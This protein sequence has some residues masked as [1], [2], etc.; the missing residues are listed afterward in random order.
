MGIPII[1]APCEAESQCA[2]L[3]KYNL[4]HATAT[5]DADALVFGTKILIRNLI[6]QK[7]QYMRLKLMIKKVEKNSLPIS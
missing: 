2:F 5:E 3:T 7:F 4:A 6:Y 1:E